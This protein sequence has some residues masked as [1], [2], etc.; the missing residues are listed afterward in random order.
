MI[1]SVGWDVE[2]RCWDVATFTSYNSPFRSCPSLCFKVRLRVKLLIWKLFFVLMQIISFTR[3]VLYFNS[4]LKG[5]VFRTQKWPIAD[6]IYVMRNSQFFFPW[7]M[8]AQKKLGMMHDRNP[9]LCPPT[10]RVQ[11][12]FVHNV[13]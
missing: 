12:P 8:M 9:L 3:K 7:C 11:C 13:Y 6:L 4:L 1:L 5:R 2:M 10:K